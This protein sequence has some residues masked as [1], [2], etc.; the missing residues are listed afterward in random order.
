[1]VRKPRNYVK[2]TPTQFISGFPSMTKYSSSLEELYTWFYSNKCRIYLS[3]IL[4]G[5]RDPEVHSKN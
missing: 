2:V 3:Y 4:Q 1:M 5:Y